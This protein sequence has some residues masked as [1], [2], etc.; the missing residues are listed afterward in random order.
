MIL[1]MIFLLISII[2]EII[3]LGLI[4]SKIIINI[5]NLEINKEDKDNLLKLEPEN[6]LGLAREIGRMLF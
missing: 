3:I 4:Y 1:I 5:E 6:Y 2:L